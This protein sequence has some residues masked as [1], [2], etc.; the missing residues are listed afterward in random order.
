MTEGGKSGEMSSSFQSCFNTA[1]H[2][3]ESSS[4]KRGTSSF[5]FATQ[6]L[7]RESQHSV[8]FS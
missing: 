7:V 8:I 3:R 4:L 2:A 6:F 1:L 5:R